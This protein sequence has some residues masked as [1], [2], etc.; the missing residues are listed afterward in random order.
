[1]LQNPTSA[2]NSPRPHARRNPVQV[3]EELGRGDL[4][5]TSARAL[6]APDRRLL[7]LLA[8]HRVLTT[9]QLARLTAIP[10][11]T[12]QY[13]LGVLFRTGL[14]SRHRPRTAVGTCP[15]HCWLTAFGT[16]AVGAEQA[17]SW[18]EDPMGM[19]TVAA[20]SDLWIDIED[21]GPTAGLTLKGWR[22][23]PDGLT[24][25]DRRTGDERRLSADAEL[26]V[27]F[28]GTREMRAIVFARLDRVPVARLASVLARWADYLQ[29]SASASATFTALVLTGGP[30]RRDAVLDVARSAPDVADHVAVATVGPQPV[31]L[32]TG[33]LWRMPVDGDDH[34]LAEVLA[35]ME[36]K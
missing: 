7:V 16:A 31:A 17:A 14:V 1:M 19:R 10:E 20:I 15:Y 21:H 5:A 4:T 11:R 25:R 28:D 2:P 30:T 24:Y 36:G 27:G 9:R 23:L 26:T 6:R 13:R 29:A 33:A 18:S 12:V 3:T 34:C 35:S 32:V 22:R 8:E